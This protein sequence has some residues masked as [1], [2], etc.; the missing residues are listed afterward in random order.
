MTRAVAG[1]LVALALTAAL[2]L[3]VA[4]LEVRPMHHDEAN[5][6]IK[7]GDLLERG[8]YRYD[9][10]DHH[11]P[12]LYYLTLPSAWAGRRHTL[13]S[14]DE[15][16]LRRVP[17]AF[18]IATI[19][20]L[21]LLTAGIGRT[22]VAVATI[23]MALSPAM[24]FYSR[25]FIQ[26][27]LF[28]CFAF[29]FVIAIGRIATNAGRTWWILAGIAAGFAAATKETA[30]I[31]LPAAIIASAIA[32]WSV[33]SRRP[34]NAITTGRWRMPLVMAVAAAASVAIVFYSSFFASPAGLLEPFRGSRTYLARG[35]DPANHAHPWHYYFHLLTYTS[36][37]GLKWSEG[38]VAGLALAG[39]VTA[40]RQYAPSDTEGRFWARYLSADVAITA[41]IFSVIPYKTP[42]NVLAF[43]VVA[44]PLAG[45]G[46]ASL[47]E[48]TRS[49]AMRGLLISGLTVACFSLGSQ[50]WRAAVTYAADPRN[51]YVYAQTVPD[52][53]RM[54]RR[55][56]DL[57]PLHADGMRMQVSVIAPPYEQWPLPWYLRGMPNVGYW[58]APGDDLAMG[59]P[60]IVSS[61]QYA[62]A[63]DAALGDRYVSEFFGLRPDVLLTL[64]IERG[65]WNRRERNGASDDSASEVKRASRGA[66]GPDDSKK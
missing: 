20:L 40:W 26:E 42:W 5:Q 49:R 53:V 66:G 9:F 48:M 1:A 33:G 62:P 63:L 56:L 46:F 45:I 10:R 51:P 11:G 64:Y 36:S 24:V 4:R 58:T 8:E 2:A 25:M 31:V 65:L 61:L 60:V 47:L 14:L 59:A 18:G 27:A 12:T 38:L 35:I 37:G 16:T 28:A 39:A 13:G 15:L 7:F 22:A 30:V 3:R 54:A 32:W 23:L 6:A 21:P 43:Y 19:L 44:F 52:A 29:A 50:A 17:V 34:S 57:A 41:S 55:I